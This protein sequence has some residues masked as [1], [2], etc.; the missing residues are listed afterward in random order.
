MTLDQYSSYLAS[1]TY[2]QCCNIP[3]KVE[4]R[5]NAEFM[6]SHGSTTNLPFFKVDN[7]L[8]SEFKHLVKTVEDREVILSNH[9]NSDQQDDMRAFLTLVH[10]VFTHAEL[11]I[12]F[13]D[14][15][16]FEKV[17][18][19]RISVAYPYLLAKVECWRKRRQVMKILELNSFKDIKVG[20]VLQ[21]VDQCCDIL[22]KKLEDKDYLCGSKPTELDAVLFGHLYAI[23][24]THLPN[25]G[26]HEI[27]KK[28]SQLLKYCQRIEGEFFKTAM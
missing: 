8:G 19:P 21:K 16:V 6:G 3:F 9:L 15:E 4:Y 17:T 10:D 26:L 22:E 13:M 27:V 18:K 23:M 2:L 24:T 20:Q 25:T 1:R 11:W 12:G 28:Y 14:E 7:F 5:S